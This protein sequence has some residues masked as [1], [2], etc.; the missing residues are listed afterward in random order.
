MSLAGPIR[1]FTATSLKIVVEQVSR[2]TETLVSSPSGSWIQLTRSSGDAQKSTANPRI[3]YFA[4][5][6]PRAPKTCSCRPEGDRGVPQPYR[7]R[8]TSFGKGVKQPSV[9]LNP[10][11]NQIQNK[12]KI[13][14]EKSLV[15]ST[16]YNYKSYMYELAVAPADN[17]LLQRLLLGREGR[18]MEDL[19]CVRRGAY[20]LIVSDNYTCLHFQVIT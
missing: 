18:G 19:A 16:F 2:D 7:A 4:K 8:E 9:V 20:R 14:T 11:H 1:A 10:S 6:S 13:V 12:N 15:S 5:T 3:A 17:S